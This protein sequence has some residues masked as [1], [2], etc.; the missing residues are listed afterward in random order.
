LLI[1]VL[2]LAILRVLPERILPERAGGTARRYT[3][4]HKS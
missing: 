1:A 2:L 3:S 4:V